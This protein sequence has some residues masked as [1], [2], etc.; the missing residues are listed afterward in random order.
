VYESDIDKV[1]MGSD[2]RI[3][4]PAYPEMRFNTTVDRVYNVLNPES[5]TLTI[6][7]KL[8]NEN[9]LLKPGMFTKVFVQY[10]AN[11]EKLPNI[12]DNSLIFDRNK[13]FVVVVN[14][15]N[16]EIREVVPLNVS[17][18]NIS[19]KKGLTAGEKIVSKNA[20]LIYNAVRT[21]K[22]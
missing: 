4:V 1:K 18:K 22:N 17:N 6:R 16:F 2:V 11:G 15:D 8:R 7:M 5:N 9:Y 10:G 12:N 20:L 21:I 19:I 13:Y 3:Y 14:G